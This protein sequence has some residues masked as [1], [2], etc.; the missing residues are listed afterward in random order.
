MTSSFD[1]GA[2]LAV[3]GARLWQH[4][5]KLAEFGA[6][7]DGGVNRQA[8][9]DEEIAAWRQMIAWA[10][11]AGLDAACDDAGNLFVTLAG[12]HRAL[13]P[14]LMGSHLDSQP[15]GGRF[16]GVYGVIAALEVLVTLKERG[17]RPDRDVVAVGWMNE[18]GSRFAPGMMGS[19]AF[20]GV[21]TLDTM[22][23]VRDAN[24]VSV[25][26]A[27]DRVHAAFADL[28]RR[29]P[30]GAAAGYVE[31]HIEQGPVLEA[32]G[33]TI[34]VVT[35]IQGKTTW[36]ITLHGAPGHAG[37]V[38]MTARQDAIFAFARIA[39]SLEDEIGRHDE[40]V[41]LTLGRVVVTPNAPSVIPEQVVFSVDLRHPDNA[42]LQALGARLEAICAAHAAPCTVEA[43]RLVDAESN[44]FAPHWQALIEASARAHGHPSM[45]ILS[46]AGHD[47]RYLAQVCPSAM[48]FIPS[49]D[50]VSHAPVEWSTPEQVSAGADVL[51]DTIA[52]WLVQDELARMP[53]LETGT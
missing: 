33:K 46:H 44:D 7:P 12:A 48:I 2:P 34:G 43:E 50:G 1:N 21:M 47:A 13:P 38:D 3:N 8:L 37:T 22:R 20:A 32:K 26:E 14:L 25:G 41:K 17:V 42:V 28:P 40:A 39:Q 53:Q 5:M 16:D 49:R 52:R 35:G 27:L 15:A 10:R 30:G 51:A 36:R 31:L 9:S 6:L 4:L 18:E 24:G 29:A 11:E 23:A 19:Q 45:P